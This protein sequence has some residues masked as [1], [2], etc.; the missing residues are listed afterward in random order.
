MA[1][2]AI[3]LV[4]LLAGCASNS[5]RYKDCDKEYASTLPHCA[6][7][8]RSRPATPEECSKMGGIQVYVDGDYKGCERRGTSVRDILRGPY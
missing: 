6:T 5:A 2:L 4:V 7:V 1:W 3:S 8:V